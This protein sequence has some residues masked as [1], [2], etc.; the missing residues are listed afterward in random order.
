M[1]KASHDLLTVNTSGLLPFSASEV[2]EQQEQCVTAPMWGHNELQALR[3]SVEV[4]SRAG[5]ELLGGPKERKG[6]LHPLKTEK[7]RKKGLPW[8]Q[9]RMICLQCV[10]IK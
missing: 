4:A 7:E 2:H 1:V 8:R 5:S 9:T 6:R 10:E 3:N